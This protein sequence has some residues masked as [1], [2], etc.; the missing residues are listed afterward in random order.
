MAKKD[1]LNGIRNVIPQEEQYKFNKIYNT[2]F[3]LNAPLDGYNQKYKSQQDIYLDLMESK[4]KDEL[5]K[6]Q[7][8]K[9]TQSLKITGSKRPKINAVGALC[10]KVEEDGN[11][12]INYGSIHN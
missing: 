4:K 9:M 11:K 10:G 12:D 2:T 6:L 3:N 5:K 1:N 8:D 7:N